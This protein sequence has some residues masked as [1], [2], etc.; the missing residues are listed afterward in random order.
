[1]FFVNS[2]N[3]FGFLTGGGG[4]SLLT[5]GGGACFGDGVDG[6]GWGLGIL[7]GGGGGG[8]SIDCFIVI[9]FNSL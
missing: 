1:M 9:D 4:D 2:S 3:Y 7:T 5:G 8:F 6:L